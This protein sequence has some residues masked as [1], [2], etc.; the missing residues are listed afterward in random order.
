MSNGHRLPNGLT[1]QDEVF[2]LKVVMSPESSLGDAYLFSR[3]N[4]DASEATARRQGKRLV[5]VPALAA[6]IAELRT[7]LEAAALTDILEVDARQYAIAVTP[8]TDVLTVEG[9]RVTIK[10]SK[11]WSPRAQAAVKAVSLKQTEDG[12]ELRVE[13]H[14][15]IQ[16]A[17]LV[18]KRRGLLTEKHEA[19]GPLVRSE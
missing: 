15:P 12:P 6:R 19:A 2:A 5:R 1:P 8:I 16:A 13:M 4:S 3:P 11:D 7:Q 18:Y 17:E 10:D 14:S 9:G